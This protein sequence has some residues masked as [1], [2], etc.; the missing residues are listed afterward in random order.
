MAFT[1]FLQSLINGFVL[2]KVEA[3][4]FLPEIEIILGYLAVTQFASRFLT[5]KSGALSI[6]VAFAWERSR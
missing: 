4:P 1:P 6:L 3:I 2:Q 5:A